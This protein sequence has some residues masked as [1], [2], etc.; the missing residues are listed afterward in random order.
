VILFLLQ[1]DKSGSIKL[2]EQRQSSQLVL[3]F[4][5]RNIINSAIGQEEHFT[6]GNGNSPTVN[7]NHLLQYMINLNPM[8][9]PFNMSIM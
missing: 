1:L 3:L 4:I 5:L 6:D 8:G 9:Y 7:H 2:K